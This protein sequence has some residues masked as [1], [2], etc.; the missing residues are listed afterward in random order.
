MMSSCAHRAK[1][2]ERGKKRELPLPPFLPWFLLL[3]VTG[4]GFPQLQKS[5]KATEEILSL[6][7]T[8]PAVL[9]YGYDGDRW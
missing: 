1:R 2:R 7:S 8:F 5:C 9:G 3:Y 4:A 6:P